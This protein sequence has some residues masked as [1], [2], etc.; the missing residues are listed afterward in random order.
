MSDGQQHHSRGLARDAA[1]GVLGRIVAM[2]CSSITALVI[3]ASL[4]KSDYGAYAIV[5]GIQ[6][7]LVMALDIGLTSALS[8]YVAQG[9]ATTRLVVQ[10]AALR[11]AIIG[12]AALVVLLAP[13]VV[14]SLEESPIGELLPAL[15]ALVVAQSLV[16]FFFGSLPSLR[17]IRLLLLVTVAQPVVELVLVLRARA[18]GGDAA[19]MILATTYAGLGVSLV[20][21]VLLL[22]PGRAAS[23]DVPEPAVTERASARMVAKYGRQLFLVSLLVAALGQVDQFVIGL[24]HPL[25]EV[26]PYALAIKVQ[27]L[28]AAPG[29][30]I[31]GIVAPRIAGAGAAAQALYR[32]WLAFLLVV[33]LGAALTI[34]VLGEQLFG[35]IGDDYVQDASLL[36]WM[37]PF[38]V[39]SA[40]APLP[41]ITLNQTGHAASRMRIA[42]Q[43][44]AINAAI[45]LALVPWLGAIGA[46]IGTTAA[47]TWYFAR[48][49]VLVERALG[50][51]AT[52]PAPTIRWVLLQGAAV[53]VL[54]AAVAWATRSRLDQWFDVTGDVAV[55]LI[56]GGI[57]AV[58]HVAWSL[59]IVRHPLAAS[60]SV[61]A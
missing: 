40:A 33:T 60:D 46:V 34:G 24:F 30:T 20:A 44:L 10:V 42:G 49:D 3:A 45:D 37:V 50:E 38:F 6:V 5:F 52:G 36:W 15:A 12:A 32:Q 56:A 9:R 17:R 53:S 18:E 11:L 2:V 27:A 61:D 41:S 28:V 54:V 58:A 25:A 39:L 23:S 48:H 29:I 59:Q 7:V 31:A 1:L 43:T 21:W 51:Q 47:F 13:Q 14:P 26:A 35:I 16:A 8:R 4:T 55:L 22:A 19:D 57:A